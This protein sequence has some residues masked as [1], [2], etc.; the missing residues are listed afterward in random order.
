MLLAL[1]TLVTADTQN[2]IQKLYN[3][4]N[5]LDLISIFLPILVINNS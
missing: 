3:I 1:F 4:E 2:L 5:I